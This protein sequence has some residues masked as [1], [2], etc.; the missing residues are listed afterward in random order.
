MTLTVPISVIGLLLSVAPAL[1]GGFNAEVD[2]LTR[3]ST[4]NLFAIRSRSSHSTALT[5][6]R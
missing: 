5:T 4:G 6:P 3:A 2:F 1:A